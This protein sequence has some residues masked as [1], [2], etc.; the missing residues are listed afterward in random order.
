MIA[1][2]PAPPCSELAVLLC[3]ARTSLDDARAQ[4]LRAL[5]QRDL[6]WPALLQMAER[7]GLAPLLYRH[8]HATCPDLLPPAILAHLEEQFFANTQHMLFLAGELRAILE[9]LEA[10]GIAALPFKGP[11]LA[12]A[13]YGNLALR[14]AGDLDLLVDPRDARAALAALRAYGYR[15]RYEGAVSSAPYR[16]HRPFREAPAWQGSVDLLRA[17]DQ[18]AVELHWRLTPRQVPFPLAPADLWR[19]R[20]TVALAGADVPVPAAEDLLLILCRHGAGHLWAS[21]RWLC[22]IA[23]L[24]RARPALHWPT[25]LRRARA[26]G[27]LRLLLLGLHLA[28]ALLEAPLPET[29]HQLVRADPAVDVLSRQVCAWLLHNPAGPPGGP[30]YIRFQRRVLERRRDRYRYLACLAL[31][32][33]RADWRLLPLPSAYRRL[34]GIYVLLRPPRLSY[35]VAVRALRSLV[36]RARCSPGRKLVAGA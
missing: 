3:C 4:R 29:I 36:A 33:D 23:E 31:I 32:P 8:L 28:H 14:Q 9:V 10:R 24:L 7:H 2:Q 5:M 30:A 35:A 11:A 25:V 22:D 27:S 1:S 12:V 6:D 16:L 13:A 26:V 19:R 21:L 15:P 17:D 20:S 18:V 34:F